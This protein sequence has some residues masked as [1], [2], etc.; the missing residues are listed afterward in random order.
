MHY[1]K[2]IWGADAHVF[3]PDRW[4]AE[5]IAAKEKYWIPVGDL[6]PLNDCTIAYLCTCRLISV[7]WRRL[8]RLSRSKH[9]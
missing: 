4:L 1:S 6:C 3:N 8:W 7:V 9:R 5:D 2:E